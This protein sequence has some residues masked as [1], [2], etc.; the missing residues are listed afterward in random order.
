METSINQV[1]NLMDTNGRRS[2]VINALNIYLTFLDEKNKDKDFKWAAF[3]NNLVQF[4]FY[5]NAIS[6]SPDVFEN[7]PKYDF[8]IDKLQ[9]EDI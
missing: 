9:Y 4:E 8:I 3:P 1:F 6:Q 7:H 5:K 2:D